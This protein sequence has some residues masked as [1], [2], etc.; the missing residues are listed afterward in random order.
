M[1]FDRRNFLQLMGGTALAA[2]GART[3]WAA[4]EPLRVGSILSVTGPAAFLGEDMK[5]GLQLAV[6]EINAAGG[7]GG[8]K[9]AWTFYDAESQT[10]KAISA[11][12]RLIS[13][14][15]VEL[16]LSGGNMSGI[17]L[18]MAPMAESASIP[19]ISSEGALA[20]VTPVAERKF[21]FKSTV[22]DEDVLERIADYF[23]KKNIKKVALIA[24]TSGFGQ[25][26]VTQMKKVGPRRNLDLIY[27]SF[28]PA[29]TDMM[30]Q[31]TRIRDSGAEAIICWTVTPAGVV[32]LKQAQQL[33]LD[34]RTLIHSYGFV[35][36]HYMN[37]AGDAAK[38]VLLASLKFP[39]GEQL[40]D[41]DP[42][43]VGILRLFRSY[44]ERF[45][46]AASL[47]A[48]ESYDAA[49]LAKEAL[50][51]VGGDVTK[52][53][54]GMEQIKNFAGMSGVFN[55]S[56]ERHSGLSKKDIV[57]INWRDGRFN[58]ADYE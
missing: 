51:K 4:D 14:D 29:D 30:P 36:S 5:A 22:D 2:T 19:F 45:N 18:A 32:F 50:N 7:I 54:Q 13:Q 34:S 37:L 10:Q 33:G 35:S 1:N 15:K 53:P 3:G 24:D 23:A 42:L 16:I 20:I 40:P 58:L 38:S 41:S 39:V 49:M 9:V 31:L 25:G 27:E 47:Y 11:T 17:A 55:F 12:R 8:R 48:A 21:V 43:K 56:P 44:Q 57:L 52:L 46:H 6:D 28:D 26:A